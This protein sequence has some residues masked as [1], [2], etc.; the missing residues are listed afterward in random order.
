MRGDCAVIVDE[1]YFVIKVFR[2]EACRTTRAA[3]L[4]CVGGVSDMLAWWAPSV[5]RSAG[6][7]VE[8]V[9]FC[10]VG[11]GQNS[12]GVVCFVDCELSD[13]LVAQYFNIASWWRPGP[14]S[15]QG[16]VARQRAGSPWQ[17]MCSRVVVWLVVLRC[18]EGK[19]IGKSWRQPGGI[20]RETVRTPC[21]RS[22]RAVRCQAMTLSAI[23]EPQV[24]EGG[25]A[26]QMRPAKTETSARRKIS[27]L[28]DTAK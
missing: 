2:L 4:H 19:Q 26:G 27:T 11:C 6:K 9:A 1:R 22:C 23:G 14:G 10:D 25:E 28:T 20:G 21:V 24:A 17:R 18:Q 5:W 13:S 3:E 15:W 12:I 7:P 8:S 16:T